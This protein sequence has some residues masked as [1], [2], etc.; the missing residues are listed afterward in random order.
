MN[1]S[2]DDIRLYLIWLSKITGNTYRLLSE[3]EW[4]YAARAGSQSIYSFGDDE[5]ELGR[6]AWF[7]E[8]SG[9]K[10]HPVGEKLPNA[11]GLHD[12]HGNVWEWMQDC[13]NENYNEAPTDGCRQS[14]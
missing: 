11:F 1:V 14:P 12:M 8:N 7:E 5:K 9:E 6:Y 3:A 10:T 2:W 13:W 4:E